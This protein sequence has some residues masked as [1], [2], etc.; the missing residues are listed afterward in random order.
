MSEKCDACDK[1]FDTDDLQILCLSCV[2]AHD[3]V[4]VEQAVHDESLRICKA[5]EGNLE[6]QVLEARRDEANW[7]HSTM[8]EALR[9]YGFRKAESG[10]IEEIDAQIKALDKPEGGGK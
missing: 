6:R 2:K 4:T 7:W 3:K 5:F 1:T 9:S 8:I 10:R